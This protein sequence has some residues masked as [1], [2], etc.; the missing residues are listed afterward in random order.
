MR[1]YT[2]TRALTFTLAHCHA[3]Q[4]GAAWT[5]E[6]LIFNWKTRDDLERLEPTFT[7]FTNQTSKVIQLRISRPHFRA[8][9]YPSN[10][11]RYVGY[12]TDET[13]NLFWL[14]RFFFT[15]HISQIPTTFHWWHS[16]FTKKT[17]AFQVPPNQLKSNYFYDILIIKNK[18]LYNI[19]LIKTPKVYS[20]HPLPATW[21]MCIS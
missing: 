18:I 20:N 6:W 9:P 17:L 14:F 1:V 16:E 21:Y 15:H 10:D 3:H 5:N 11:T 4:H 7:T 2:H 12:W 8:T 19:D 13:F